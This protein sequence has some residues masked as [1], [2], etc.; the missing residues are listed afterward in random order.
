MTLSVSARG[1]EADAFIAGSVNWNF[2][3]IF[4]TVHFRPIRVVSVIP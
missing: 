3:P 4:V 2:H 1:G